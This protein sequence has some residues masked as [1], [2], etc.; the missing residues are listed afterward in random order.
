ML[1]M[2]L[3]SASLFAQEMPP[4]QVEVVNVV[5]K[6]MAPT[7]ELQ[8]NVVSLNDAQLAAEVEGQLNWIAEVGTQVSKGDVIAGIDTSVL[9]LNLTRAE[10]SLARL[11]ADLKFREREVVRFT[12][13]AKRDNTSKTRLQQELATKEM[14]QSD[15]VTAQA[16]I[17]LVKRDLDKSQVKAPFAGVL[18]NKLAH[19]GEYLSLGEPLLRLVDISNKEISVATPIA[20]MHLLKP[21]MAVA[22]KTSSGIQ[23]LPVRTIVPVGDMSSR[24]VEVRL[25]AAGTALAVGESVKALMPKA[26][27]KEAVS[28][29]RDA[30]VIRGAQT[31]VYKVNSESKAE[32]VEAQIEFAVGD[33]VSVES[34]IV[35]GDKVIVRGAER[36]MPGQKVSFAE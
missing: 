26:E 9:Q 2:G 30:L 15:I 16:S 28:V 10:A 22:V 5:K 24:M 19:Q 31:F 20:I 11:E 18:V 14:L 35:A 33:W 6:L 36:L 13:L 17:A 23:Q 12:E 4:A 1:A 29:P 3:I 8:G 34:G 25:Q 27:S 7:M 32:Q 21:Q